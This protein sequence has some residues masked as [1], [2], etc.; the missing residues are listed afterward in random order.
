MKEEIRRVSADYAA[1]GTSIAYASIGE[2]D[3]ARYPCRCQCSKCRAVE[4]EEGSR[5]RLLLRF[6]NSV[7]PTWRRSFPTS[8]SA[9]W[10]TIPG[11]SRQDHQTPLQRDHPPG[12]Y[13]VLLQQ[14]DL[15][16][17]KQEFRDDLL[18]GVEDRGVVSISGT[19]SPTSITRCCRTPEPPRPGAERQFFASH[20][21]KG[22]FAEGR[23]TGARRHPALEMAE[24]R[25]WVLAK[26]MWD[27]SL[28]GQKLMKSSAG[29]A[30]G[31]AADGI[32]GLSERH[33][34]CRG[35]QRRLAGLGE[36]R[37]PRLTPSFLSSIRSA[38]MGDICKRPNARPKRSGTSCQGAGRPLPVLYVFIMALGGDAGP[39]RLSRRAMPLPIRFRT[40]TTIS[41]R[42]PERMR[43]R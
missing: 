6:T 40:P 13:R 19:R 34:R 16:S 10:P 17:A 42:L 28:D 2:S 8:G 4:I 22:M 23:P 7:A 32:L 21:V 25:S 37:P 35:G 9:C 14:A 27:P 31:P 43:Y 3:D 26:L 41:S 12:R 20:G 36:I 38:G 33:P 39:G 24:L 29:A 15:R 5:G 18:L 30:T 11:E 1:R